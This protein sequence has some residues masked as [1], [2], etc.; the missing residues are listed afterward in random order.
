MEHGQEQ[1]RVS[2]NSATH[3]NRMPDIAAVAIGRNEGERLRRCL[4]SMRGCFQRL[5][6]VD[7]GS[8]DNS[9][10]IA[11]AAGVEVVEL[12]LS[13]PFTAA[14]ARN[15]GF[16]ALKASGSLNDFVQFVDGD[17]LLQPEWIE[18]AAEAMIADPG[19]GIVTGWRSEIHRN[20]T[21]YNAICDFEWRRPAGDILTCGGDMLV[22]SEAFIEVGGFNDSIIAAEDDEFCVRIR[23]AGW[24]IR[25]LPVEMTLHDAAMTRF[26]Q[27]WQRAVRSGHGFAQVGDIHP[28]YF[29]KERRRVWLFGLVLPTIAIAGVL[30]SVL[31]PL[32]VAALYGASYLRTANGLRR[33]G[34]STREALSHAC[35]ITFSKFPNVIGMLTYFWRQRKGHRMN[36]IEYK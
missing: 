19:L 25:R 34:L 3:T 10:E 29:V 33:E 17:C 4:A 9:I 16:A 5:V 2:A 1:K 6:Y 20:A 11:H 36:I 21:I 15:A 24:R 7:S 12:D 22:R 14:R 26:S 23:A 18:K 32:I 28:T 27:W 8:T 31:V 35:F 13:K 30:L